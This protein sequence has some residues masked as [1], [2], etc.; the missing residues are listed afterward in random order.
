MARF[1][2]DENLPP[3]TAEALRSAG[4]DALHVR[5]AGLGGQSDKQV[6]AYAQA[7]DAVLVTADKDF[8]SILSFPLGSHSG[9]VV[10]RL[11][12]KMPLAERNER[13]LV[14]IADLGAD[15]LSGSLVILDMHGTRVRRTGPITC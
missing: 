9:I 5:D 8:T 10:S 14:A 15:T 12:N 13:L 6:F 7:A 3:S 4:Y 11:P 2:V 1:L